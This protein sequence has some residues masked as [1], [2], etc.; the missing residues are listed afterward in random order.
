MG[1]I[2]KLGLG[3]SSRDID[4]LMVRFDTN[5]DGKIDYSEFMAKFKETSYDSRMQMRAKTRMASLKG[6]MTMHM[7]SANDAFR[8]FDIEK[9]GRITFAEFIKLVNKVHELAGEKAPTYPIIKDLFDAIDIRKDGV[10]DLHEWQQSF[11]RVGQGPAKASTTATPLTMWENTKDFERIGSLM[12]KNRKLL[13]EKFKTVLG[14][15]STLFTFEEG[16]AALDDWISRT[17]RTPSPMNS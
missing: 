5:E 8:F 11:G 16:K 10:I 1:A 15:S 13:I 2:R 14:S 17:S 9:T 12:A 3:L 4:Q 7:T 6:L